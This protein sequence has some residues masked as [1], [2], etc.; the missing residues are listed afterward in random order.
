[1][2]YD[3]YNSYEDYNFFRPMNASYDYNTSYYYDGTY[4]R[5][6]NPF[7]VDSRRYQ[8]GAPQP[9]YIPQ[10]Q[11]YSPA[12]Y[13]N[14]NIPGD[15]RRNDTVGNLNT[16]LFRQQ[17]AYS[18]PINVQPMQAPAPQRQMYNGY[19]PVSQFDN[20]YTRPP[21]PQQPS[22][23]WYESNQRANRPVDPYPAY[24]Y[25]GGYQNNYQNAYQAKDL[26]W[27]AIVKQNFKSQN[28]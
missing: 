21:V 15:S 18:Q 13:Q 23:N 6:T 20:A 22:I 14:P 19:A 25:T 3:S 5:P 16:D 11:G 1:M 28:L 2:Y 9:T 7:D 17:Q 10:N 27:S 24:Q 26:D 12:P 4:S 8:T